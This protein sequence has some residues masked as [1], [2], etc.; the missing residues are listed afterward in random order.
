[1]HTAANPSQMY[2]QGSALGG[3]GGGTEGLVPDKARAVGSNVLVAVIS[4]V[5]E[6]MDVPLP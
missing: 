5:G 1:M 2:A 6:A 4:G 3:V